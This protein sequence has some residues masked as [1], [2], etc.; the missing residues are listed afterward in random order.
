MTP[1]QHLIELGHFAVMLALPAA[2]LIA[3][4][5][6]QLHANL[7]V[8][9]GKQ[10]RYQEALDEARGRAS[11]AFRVHQE[12]MELYDRIMDIN[13]KSMAMTIRHV[14][15]VMRKQK[16]RAICCVS[17]VSAQRGGGILGGPH[18][19]AAK[20]GVLGLARAMAR[21]FGIDGVRVNCI[22]PGLIETDITQGKLSPER[23]KEIEDTIPLARLGDAADVAR[24][25]AATTGPG[26][27]DRWL[28]GG[29]EA[30]MEGGVRWVEPE[31]KAPVRPE[32]PPAPV[33]WRAPGPLLQKAYRD[34]L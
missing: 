28:Q 31:S 2:L 30:G 18:Y 34:R 4:A 22:T 20:A 3:P 26:E 29:D 33:R 6:P 8:Y 12:L 15:P 23:K 10:G 1:S 27:P 5:H 21:E 32:G 7:S 13:L 24:F 16:S 11:E 25:W 17:S 14:L 9:L 19:S